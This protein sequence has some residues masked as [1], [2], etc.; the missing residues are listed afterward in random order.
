MRAKAVKHPREWD[1]TSF[2]ELAA[3]RQ[4]YRIVNQ[5]RL[6]WCLECAGQ[7]DFQNWYL[8]TIDQECRTPAPQLVREP[9]WTRAAAVGDRDWIE[10]IARSMPQHLRSITPPAPAATPTNEP[11]AYT[12]Q[13]SNRF[14][15]GLLG[16][17]DR[18]V[19][20]R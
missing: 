13:T 5:Q 4:R 17:L 20:D 14:R 2:H 11:A 18:A 1:A 15:E 16:A 3:E 8:K 12:L 7:D 19:D 10:K 9:I 6:Y